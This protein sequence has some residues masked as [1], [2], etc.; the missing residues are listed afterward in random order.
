MSLSIT[1]ARSS[2]LTAAAVALA[3]AGALAVPQ[4]AGAAVPD[5]GVFAGKTKQPSSNPYRYGSIRLG[6]VDAG[7]A[8][9][10]AKVT[11]RMKMKCPGGPARRLT[12]RL[13]I[14]GAADGLVDSTGAFEYTYLTTPTSGFTIS[15]KFSSATQASGTLGRSDSHS[16]CYTGQIKWKAT[17]TQ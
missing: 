11:V 1:T 5:A 3:A 8:R 13:P 9:K 12:Y 15:G 4:L 10:L 17:L 6:V 14:P 7:G 2:R 16:G